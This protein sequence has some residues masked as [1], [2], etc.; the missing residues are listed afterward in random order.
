[1]KLEEIAKDRKKEYISEKMD[2]RVKRGAADV[3]NVTEYSRCLQ[4]S[5]KN[6]CI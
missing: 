5:N 4:M 3:W 6:R 1:V 2:H